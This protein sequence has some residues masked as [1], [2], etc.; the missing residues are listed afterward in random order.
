LNFGFVD[1]WHMFLP[2][3]G[4]HVIGVMG[5]G[6][7]TSLLLAMAEMY[8][9]I[10][11]PVVL[12]TTT[13]SE[14]LPLVPSVEYGELSDREISEM[15][16]VFFLH[17]GTTSDGKWSGLSSDQV[18]ALGGIFPDR[19]ILV[20]VD[21]AARFPVKIHKDD[22]PVWPSRTSLGIVVMGTSA[23]GSKTE[24]VLHRF[25]TRDWP[26]LADLK[27]WTVWEWSHALDLLLKPGGYLARV[28][29][30][31]PCVLALTGMDEQPD[32]IGL[33]EFVGQAMDNPRLPL[34]MFCDFGQDEPV[35]RTACNEEDDMS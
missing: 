16:D 10:P 4:G 33:F 17:G 13:R 14:M 11:L 26:P 32:S 28:P 5:S 31:I 2:R 25:G 7:K 34:T 21:G 15:P 24:D 9:K 27:S 1:P 8:R 23:V 19:V 22:E 6:G 20:E 30:G 12:T 29:E 18:D 35:I 3:E